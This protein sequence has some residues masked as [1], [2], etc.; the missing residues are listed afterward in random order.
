MGYV[1]AV[2]YLLLD[3]I[4]DCGEEFMSRTTSCPS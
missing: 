4:H 1:V 2:A 3:G